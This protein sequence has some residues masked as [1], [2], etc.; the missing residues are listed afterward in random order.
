MLAC[1]G[2]IGDSGACGPRLMKCGETLIEVPLY[3]RI[4]EFFRPGRVDFVYHY[5]HDICCG[6]VLFID[7][8]QWW[9]GKLSNIWGDALALLLAAISALPVFA[10]ADT[11]A[12][13]L[14]EPG[15][16]RW[17]FHRD[18]DHLSIKILTFDDWTDQSPNELGKLQLRTTVL[19]W[20]FA[21]RLIMV[22]DRVSQ[23]PVG[24]KQRHITFAE[25]LSYQALRRALKERKSQ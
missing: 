1:D 5:G 17:I 8:N 6:E 3:K 23:N 21:R 24:A 13:W 7:G 4:D 20:T 18:Q 10:S 22:A 2:P 15:E 11:E 25:D 14:G 16:T 9:Y 19:F 12:R